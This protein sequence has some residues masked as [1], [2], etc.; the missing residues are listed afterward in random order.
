MLQMEV[1]HDAVEHHI[2]IVR[3]LSIA[4]GKRSGAVNVAAQPH[5]S[6]LSSVG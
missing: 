4:A 1:T 3:H 6:L 2:F 5:F